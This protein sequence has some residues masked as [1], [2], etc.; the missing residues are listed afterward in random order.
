MH[1]RW[2]A[3]TAAVLALG[4]A[5]LAT[6]PVAEAR[7]DAEPRATAA[8]T[9]KARKAVD[10]AVRRSVRREHLRA[11]I[12][13]VTVDGKRVLRRAYGESQP[14]VPARTDMHFRNGAVAIAYMST[15]LLRL[16]DDGTV[17]L[18]DR[19]SRW[20]PELRDSRRVTLGQLAGMTAGYHDYVADPGLLDDVYL[21][22]F[23]PVTTKRQLAL[24]LSR[25][26]LFAPGTN[27]SY[28]HSDYVILG[29]AL[30][31]ITGQRLATA[32]R[33]RVLRPLG[34]RATRSSQSAAI[35]HPA[36]H[37][38]SA[39]RRE[40]LGIPAGTPFIEESTSWSP[41]WT[42]ARGAV[43]T[44]TISDMTRTAIGIGEGRLLSK[45]SYRRQ[46]DPRIGFGRPVDGCEACRTFTPAYGFGLG[47][48]RH[49]GW[50]MQTPMFAG[51]AA[52]AAYLP[53]KRVSIAVAVTFTEQAFD[54]EGNAGRGHTN[55]F[56]AIAETVAPGSSPAP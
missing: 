39:E 27:W 24:A 10:R 13:E 4:A 50:I 17:R 30:E 29:L 48:V 40:P 36:L 52:V 46:I 37:A 5:G 42:L 1:A 8:A 16:V 55:L 15:L 19:V 49:G 20:L 56:R 7:G 51:S 18:D 3:S 31:K 9:A 33:E 25:P 14:G 44:T 12:V 53:G 45:R 28:S 23:R 26:L 6:A 54:A 41:A 43:Q 22:P 32:L 35:P 38:F 11:A 21:R 34:L 2:I 47:V